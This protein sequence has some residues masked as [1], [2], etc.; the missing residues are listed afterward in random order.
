MAY[1]A[2]PAPSSLLQVQAVCRHGS[3]APTTSYPTDPHGDL[4]WLNGRSNLVPAGVSDQIELGA[5]L[6][7]RYGALL[8]ADPCRDLCVVASDR[9]R[10][11]ESARALL[12]GLFDGVLPEDGDF[13]LRLISQERCPRLL[14]GIAKELHGTPEYRLTHAGVPNATA[15]ELVQVFDVLRTQRALG[16]RLPDWVERPLSAGGVTIYAGMERVFRLAFGAQGAPAL[17]RL[18]AGGLLR[19]LLNNALLVNARAERRTPRVAV[20]AAHDTTLAALEA[21]LGLYRLP[22]LPTAV[23]QVKEAC[24]L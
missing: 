7:R 11:Q 3:R 16:L 20:F 21:A 4:Q 24:R 2:F 19:T 22:W 9:N 18:S 1:A 5:F 23:D 6:W 17:R 12:L 15:F 13:V 14:V 8:A 10:T